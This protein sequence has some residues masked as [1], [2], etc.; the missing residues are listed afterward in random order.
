MYDKYISIDNAEQAIINFT[1]Y[2]TERNIEII[3]S[4]QEGE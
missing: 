4:T 3:S 1:Y 2:I